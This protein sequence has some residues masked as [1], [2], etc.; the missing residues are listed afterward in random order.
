MLQ[1]VWF[2]YGHGFW[3]N[4]EYF[5]KVSQNGTPPR[6]GM[7]VSEDSQST[8]KLKNLSKATFTMQ[9]SWTCIQV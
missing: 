2:V 4:F 6:P 7:G 8:R 5:L 3:T 9:S 1:E